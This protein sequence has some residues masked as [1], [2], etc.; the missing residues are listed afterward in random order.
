MTVRKMRKMDKE[1]CELIVIL[2]LIAIFSFL[3][4]GHPIYDY[5]LR[6]CTENCKESE[7]DIYGLRAPNQTCYSECGDLCQKVEAG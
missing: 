3:F 4:F 1:T 5:M 6:E 2:S 7:C